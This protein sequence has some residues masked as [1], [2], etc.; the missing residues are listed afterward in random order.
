MTCLDGTVKKIYVGTTMAT[1][2][3]EDAETEISC[4]PKGSYDFRSTLMDAYTKVL[5][6]QLMKQLRENWQSDVSDMALAKA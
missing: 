1:N 6:W 3:L 5:T 2:M 4:G